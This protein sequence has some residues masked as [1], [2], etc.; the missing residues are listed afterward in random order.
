MKSEIPRMIFVE[1]GSSTPSSVKVE[2]KVGTTYTIIRMP[3]TT[4]AKRMMPG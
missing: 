4:M 2:A 1:V 3:M